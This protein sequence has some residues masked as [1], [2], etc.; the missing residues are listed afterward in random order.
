MR[1]DRGEQQ[2]RGGMLGIS[3]NAEEGMSDWQPIETA[4]INGAEFLGFRRGEIA[5][6][7]RVQRDDCE[8]WAFGRSSASVDTCPAFKPTHWMPLPEAP[9]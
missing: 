4:P 6:T 5:V 7:Y 1:V 8:M 2:E 9:K 3:G